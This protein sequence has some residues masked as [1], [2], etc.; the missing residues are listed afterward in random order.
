MRRGKLLLAIDQFETGQAAADFTIGLTAATGAEV[1]VIHVR[2]VPASLRIPPLETI[3]DARV[4]V[5]ETVQR[6]QRAGIHAEGEVCSDRETHVAQRIVDEASQRGCDAIVLG[7][8]RRR[9]L[10]SLLGNGIR[11]R[12][13]KRSSL[14]VILAPPALTTRARSLAGL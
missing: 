6:M 5:D 10:G 13:L 8:Q 12:V 1:Q 9:G 11:Q 3:A 2:E 4:L 7:S 14:P